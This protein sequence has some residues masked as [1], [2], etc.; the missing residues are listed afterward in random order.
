VIYILR[1]ECERSKACRATKDT[2]YFFK[3]TSKEILAQIEA[4]YPKFTSYSHPKKAG[5]DKRFKES[6]VEMLAKVRG[7][8]RWQ[9]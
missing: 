6:I 7:H 9:N 8:A 2:I 5:I 1:Q 4:E 3:S